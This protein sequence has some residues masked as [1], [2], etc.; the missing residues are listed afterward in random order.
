MIP[1]DYFTVISKSLNGTYYNVFAKKIGVA[2]LIAKLEG[3]LQKVWLPKILKN[4]WLLCCQYG[5]I[6]EWSH[7][8]SVST[9]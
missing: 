1:D 7:D 5:I 2:T 8:R 6:L 9:N 3:V 4:I